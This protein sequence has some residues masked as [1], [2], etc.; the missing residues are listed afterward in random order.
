MEVTPEP[1]HLQSRRNRRRF[2]S[3]CFLLAAVCLATAFASLSIAAY[4]SDRFTFGPVP[5]HDLPPL[6]IERESHA[7][8]LFLGGTCCGV[9]TGGLGLAALAVGLAQRMR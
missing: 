8:K 5:G 1:C 2:K 7:A 9:P 6:D 4:N 3:A